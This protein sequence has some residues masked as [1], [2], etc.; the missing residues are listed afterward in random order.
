MLVITGFFS[1]V[2][3]QLSLMQDLFSNWTQTLTVVVISTP[4]IVQV[5]VVSVRLEKKRHNNLLSKT[6]EQVPKIS[7]IPVCTYL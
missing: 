3:V 4:G 6:D 2:K 7:L 5:M 1:Y